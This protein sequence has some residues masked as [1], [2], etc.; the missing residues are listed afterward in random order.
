[1]TKQVNA[2]LEQVNEGRRKILGMMLA[3]AAIAPILTS[4]AF[5]ATGAQDTGDKSHKLKAA[6]AAPK[7][8]KPASKVVKSP[9][10][11]VA[12]KPGSTAS[13]DKKHKKGSSDTET[14][15]PK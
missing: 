14:N 7:T 1:M 10:P 3:G 4:T 8:T 11:S 13:P 12:P 15:P 6:T 9:A 5:G 2:A